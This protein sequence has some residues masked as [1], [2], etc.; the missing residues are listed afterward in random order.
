MQLFHSKI[1]YTVKDTENTELR[2]QTRYY[3]SYTLSD[4]N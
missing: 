2:A 3:T 1:G 4:P